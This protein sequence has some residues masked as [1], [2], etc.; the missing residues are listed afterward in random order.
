MDNP[1]AEIEISDPMLYMASLIGTR[2]RVHWH[3]RAKKW[4]VSTKTDGGWRV[5]RGEG[6]EQVLFTK[7]V[8]KDVIFTVREAGRQRVLRERR[9]NVHA[10]M[11]GTVVVLDTE[12]TVASVPCGVQVKYNPYYLPSFYYRR[13]DL[14]DALGTPVYDAEFAAAGSA[15]GV[16][17]PG[18]ALNVKTPVT[19]MEVA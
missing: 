14:T 4:S 9:K 16:L 17:V 15:N 10:W 2:V 3:L 1:C 11:E 19:G 6:G 13:D 5:V 7:V 12:N 18:W 8:L